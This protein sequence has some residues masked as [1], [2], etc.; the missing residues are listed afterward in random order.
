LAQ[1]TW[2]GGTTGSWFDPANWAG[3]AVPDL[4]NV[5]NVTIPAGVTVSFDHV[6]VSPAQAGAVN[7]DSL[8]TAGSLALSAGSLNVGLGGVT[9]NSLTQT[10]GALVTTGAL[11]LGSLS[12]S[13]GSLSA[14]SLST[15]AYNQS[16]TGTIA[17]TGNVAKAAS[18][19]PVLLGNLSTGG[20]LNLSSTGGSISQTAGTVLNVA[21]PATL[22]ASQGGAAADVTL[23]N[24]GNALNGPV[25]ATGADVTLRTTGALTAS[26]TATGNATL[27]SGGSTTL[28]ATMV[29]GDLRVTTANADVT[30]TGPL[31]V[32]GTTTLDA[33]AGSVQLTDAGNRLVGTVKVTSTSSAIVGA[34]SSARDQAPAVLTPKVGQ[35]KLPYQVTLVQLPQKGEAGQVHVELQNAAADAQIALPVALQNWIAAAGPALELDGLNASQIEDI[36]VIDNGATLSLRASLRRPMPLEFVIRAGREQVKVRIVWKP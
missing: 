7:V 35:A 8:G 19:A 1:V 25:T 36:K 3:G 15:T 34:V 33:G 27:T 24:A 17:V 4:A 26:V 13:A 20:A 23:D 9:L 5:A 21:G 31:V 2:V 30:Q 29:G 14:D 16:G 12:Q 22:T 10:G 6:A 28:G 11:A 18:A 32:G